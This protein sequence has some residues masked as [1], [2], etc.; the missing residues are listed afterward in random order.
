VTVAAL[1]IELEREVVVWGLSRMHRPERWEW[2]QTVEPLV[3]EHLPPGTRL[4][5][6]LTLMPVWYRNMWFD[7]TQIDGRVELDLCDETLVHLRGIEPVTLRIE[8]S[9][10]VGTHEFLD[11]I[12]AGT[13]G[14][15]S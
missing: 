2:W 10:S 8:T 7:S 13:I 6:P 15:A 12:L 3:R 5:L 9:Y 11:A 14:D 4:R 1:R